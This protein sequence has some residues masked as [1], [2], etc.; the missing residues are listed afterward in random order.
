MTVPSPGNGAH[1]PPGAAGAALAACVTR[2]PWRD[3]SAGALSPAGAGHRAAGGSVA[4]L[5]RLSCPIAHVRVRLG[6]LGDHLITESYGGAAMIT[7]RI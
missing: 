7:R 3:G 2:S 5:T 1:W 4:G 6:R